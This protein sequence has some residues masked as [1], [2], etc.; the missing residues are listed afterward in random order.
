MSRL[1]LSQKIKLL[2]YTGTPIDSAGIKVPAYNWWNECLHGVARAGKATVFPQ[3]IGLAA[4]WDKD[5]IYQVSSAISDEARAKFDSFSKNDKRGIYQGLN[6]WTPNINIFRDPRWGRGMETYGEDPYLTGTMA[7]SFIRGIQGNNPKY[8]KA[9]ATVKHFVVHSGPESTR[10]SFDAE[11]SDNDFYQTY[12]PAFKMCIQDA[13]VYSVMCAYNSFRGQ[14]C[15][16]NSFL[17]SDLLRKQWGFKGFIVTD[18]GAVGDFYRP[19]T[20]ETVS[21]PEEASAMAIKA[22]VDLECGGSFDALP[23]AIQKKLITP[24]EL[25]VAVERLFTAR[26][27]LGFFDDPKSAPYLQLPYSVVESAGHKKLA[28]QAAHK[29]IVLLKNQ[30]NLL[31]LSKKVKTLAIIGPNADNAEVMLAN[32]HGFP[33]HVVTPLEGLQRKL[34][35]TSILYAKGCRYADEVPSLDVIPEK[36][37]YTSAGSHEHGINARYYNNSNFEGKPTLTRIDKKVDFYWI[38]ELPGNSFDRDDFSAIWTGYIKPPISGKYNLGVSGYDQCQL[39]VN[40]SLLTSFKSEHEPDLKYKAIEL[41]AGVAYKIEVK[42]ASTK[43]APLIKLKWELP[44][45]DLQ[46]EALGKCKNADAVIMCMGLSPQIEGEEMDLVVDGFYKGDRTKLKLPDSQLQLMKAVKAL[47]KPIILVLING[48]ALAVNWESENI[49]AIVEAWYSGQ[50]GGNAIADILTGDYIPAGRL[51]ITFYK[52][53]DQLPKFDNYDM[54]ERTY[55][56]FKG[57]PL[58]EF[59]YGLSYTTF[60]YSNIKTKAVNKVNTPVVVTAEIQNTGKY[61]GAEVAQLYVKN[62]SNPDEVWSLKGFKKLMLKKG[63]KKVVQFILKPGDFSIINPHGERVINPGDFTIYI[64]GK[65][66]AR[67][68]T[69]DETISKKITL[70][71]VRSLLKL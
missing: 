16:G 71:G 50:E 15:C 43:S 3:T 60:K 59:G 37:F 69:N 27:K 63:E 5:L 48:S 62:N 64:G 42:F 2:R 49:P 32:Y 14:P 8:Y 65:Q 58:Y 29:S 17:L 24:A 22:G 57:K 20:H 39:F 12:T 13:N 44:N 53:E 9:I 23:I 31:P 66:P 41:K 1:T 6:F 35:N 10:H 11:V 52:S 26:F 7:S 70:T 30:D 28:L 61:S 68:A 46:A 36:Y 54:K 25:D 34:P 4:T 67:L 18:C 56:Y 47:G 45:Q 51:P 40:D 38:N 55:R 21:T 33:T 19:G